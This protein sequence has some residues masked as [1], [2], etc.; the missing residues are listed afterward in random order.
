MSR[1]SDL[2]GYPRKLNLQEL[3]EG[4]Y[5]PE[6]LRDWA[7]DLLAEESEPWLDY[8]GE[9]EQAIALALVASMRPLMDLFAQNSV[10]SAEPQMAGLAISC[11]TGHAGVLANLRGIARDKGLPVAE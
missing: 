4:E 1:L 11:Y 6:E 5:T 3:M 2:E 10:L 8:E 7:I 9:V